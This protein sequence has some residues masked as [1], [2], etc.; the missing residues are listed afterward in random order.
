[1][2]SRKPIFLVATP[3]YTNDSGGAKVLHQLCHLL[4]EL[5]EAYVVP[6][7]RGSIL[8]WLNINQVEQLVAA[9]KNQLENFKTC[10]SL[11]TPIF[12]KN[13]DLDVE[14]C[15]AVYPEVV[16][17]NPFQFRHVARWVLYHSGFH[18]RISCTSKGEVEFKY[19]QV[20]TGAEI[21]GFSETADFTL[22]VLMPDEEILSA[23]R[24]DIN[25]SSEELHKNR[26]GVAYCVRKGTPRQNDLIN[27]DAICIDGRSMDEIIDILKNVKYFISFDPSTFYSEVAV[28]LGCY[29]LVSCPKYDGKEIDAAN[30]RPHLAFSPDQIEGSWKRRAALLQQFERAAT[31]SRQNVAQFY[32]F[33]VQRINM[34]QSGGL[35]NSSN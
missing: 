22:H 1:M 20:F 9:E 24:R 32:E 30:E 14:A 16:F 12:S 15:V 29:S 2:K 8:N 13:S 35:Q 25:A 4:N 18:R 34:G 21:S 19:S 7:P 23:L 33:W 11:N 17:G 3:A 27:E 5:G 26:G 10:P 28:A 6:L 31:L